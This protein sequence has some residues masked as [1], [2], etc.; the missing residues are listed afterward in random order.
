M[1][2]VGHNLAVEWAR[3][4]T[5]HDVEGLLALFTDDAH[6][7]DIALG[8]SFC[9]K[10]ALR[11]FFESTFVTFPDFEMTLGN[12]IATEDGAAGEWEMSGT[13]AGA[14]FGHAPTGK[15]FRVKGCC[16]MR[17]AQGRIREHRDYW[18]PR[19]FDEQVGI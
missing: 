8:H 13:F 15:T 7:H 6:Y 1:K 14:S 11:T 12:A 5:A 4:W 2:Q 19:A 9:G 17:I 16:F 10:A 3:F 18:N